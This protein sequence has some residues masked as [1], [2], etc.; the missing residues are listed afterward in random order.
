[1]RTER[2]TAFGKIRN[3]FHNNKVCCVTT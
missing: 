1:M 2:R 3:L